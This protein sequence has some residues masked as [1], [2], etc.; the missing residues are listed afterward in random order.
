MSCSLVTDAMQQLLFHPARAIGRLSP[1]LPV[2]DAQA[3]AV[4]QRLEHRADGAGRLRL[5]ER[6]APQQ[7]VKP[8]AAL[9]QLLIRQRH[10]GDSGDV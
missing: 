6:T 8:V 4:G 9:T 7:L 1:S 2:C 5:T 10:S 3:V